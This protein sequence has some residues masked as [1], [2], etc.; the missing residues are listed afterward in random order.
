[1]SS[2]IITRGCA[3]DDAHPL[4]ET[5][6]R[7][8]N[9]ELAI[10]YAFWQS[11]PDTINVRSLAIGI[12][13]RE[14]LERISMDATAALTPGQQ[15]RMMTFARSAPTAIDAFERFYVVMGVGNDS[16]W[17]VYYERRLGR[18]CAHAIQVDTDGTICG[19]VDGAVAERFST[20][21]AVNIIPLFAEDGSDARVLSTFKPLLKLLDT[22][23]I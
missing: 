7:A 19:A 17:I 13:E 4:V 15:Q 9:A 8:S 18:S 1:M 14:I 12:I 11:Q 20:L 3:P 23:T 16:V 6:A 22:A 5:A 21:P 2:E 10:I